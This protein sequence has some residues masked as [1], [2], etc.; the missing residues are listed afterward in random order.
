[1]NKYKRTNFYEKKE[2]GGVLECDF[3]RDYYYL[4][5]IKRP[6]TFFTVTR[7]FIQRPDLLSLRLYGKMNYWPIIGYVNDIH[8]WWNDLQIED[9][10]QVP[11]IRD[12]EDWYLEVRKFK[13]NA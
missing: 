1:M 3:A 7:P 6:A 5:E 4:F 11:D 13:K 10:I 9:V 12:I 2:V 8:D